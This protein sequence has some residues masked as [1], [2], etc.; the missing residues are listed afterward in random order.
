MPQLVSSV[1]DSKNWQRLRQ[2]T[3]P[4]LWSAILI[5]TVFFIAGF[6]F[7]GEAQTMVMHVIESAEPADTKAEAEAPAP[8]PQESTLFAL[9]DLENHPDA[10]HGAY[11]AAPLISLEK[12]PVHEAHLSDFRDLLDIY[13]ARQ[14][15]DD[16]FTVRVI[17]RRTSGLLERYTLED[18]RQEYLQTGEADWEAI[19]VLRGN[20]SSRLIGKYRRRGVPMED[21]MVKWGRLDQVKEARKR[22]EPFIAYEIGLSRLLNLSLLSTELGTVETFNDDKLISTVGARSRYQIMPYML[23]RFGIY[24]YDLWT[25]SGETV[26]VNED[27]HPLLTMEASFTIIK[28]YSNA[29][30]HEIP[31]I[32]A[33]HTGPFNIFKIYNKYLTSQ[34]AMFNPSA[35]VMDAYLWA[36][37]EGFEDVSE[38]SGFRQ[39]SRSYIPTAYGS[40]KGAE[41]IPVDTARTELV[42]RV[43]SIEGERLYL[44]D[45]LEA[46][47]AFNERLDWGRAV[48]DTSYYNR[49]KALN[50][51]IDLPELSADGLVPDAGNV[52]LT[53][54]R[55]SRPV[56]FFLPE[57]ATG[58]LESTG[59]NKLDPALTFTF[60]HD[61]YTLS[62]AQV[63]VWDKQYEELVDDIK[64]FGFTNENRTRLYILTERFEKL[65][66][67]DASH[68]RDLQLQIIKMHK[69]L[70]RTR[71]WSEL[72]HNTA[73]ASGRVEVST[74]PPAP[75]GL[76]QRISFDAQSDTLALDTATD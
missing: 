68:Y 37:T 29:V 31:G 14:S 50:P 44:A 40:L 23:R 22:D 27:W 70:W 32:S 69:N 25:P 75:M 13:V 16:N 66:E 54:R 5:A 74:L 39:Y 51:H 26:T 17:D 43:Q 61:T 20:M 52:L 59:F 38:S 45:L 1:I 36:L 62:D 11:T 6:V 73:A 2:F 76:T 21:I 41:L 15:D 46:L 34:Q 10:L 9:V 24:T 67:A 8:K 72:A 3:Y 65:Y 56:R 4:A 63:T 42:E 49:F 71:Y 28:G 18:L 33:Y 55:S 57:G 60:N 47:K 64:H 48:A 19:D 30:G 7:S 58:M 35:T 53:T 12:H